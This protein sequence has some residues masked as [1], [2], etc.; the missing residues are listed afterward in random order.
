MKICILNQS[1]VIGLYC[2]V[3]RIPNFSNKYK[4]L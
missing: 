2:N 3:E 1:A 4:Q